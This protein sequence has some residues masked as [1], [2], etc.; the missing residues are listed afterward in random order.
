[1]K[2]ILLLLGLVVALSGCMKVGDEYA[3][4]WGSTVAKNKDDI[5]RLEEVRHTNAYKAVSEE[6]GAERVDLGFRGT[7]V[8]KDGNACRISIHTDSGDLDRWIA[9]DD[10]KKIRN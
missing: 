10:L 4:T 6:V 7:L 3:I 5:R 2:M 9:C 1:M 8:E